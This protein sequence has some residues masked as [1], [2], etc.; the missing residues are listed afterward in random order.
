MDRLL[1]LTTLII[2]AALAACSTLTA[3]REYHGFSVIGG[4]S[5]LELTLTLL[6]PVADGSVTGFYYAG[7]ARGDL[8]GELDGTSFTALLQPGANCT[9]TFSGTLTESAVTGTLTPFDCAG[10]EAGKWD[11]QR[12]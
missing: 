8:H 5:I 9:F 3:T 6:E 12:Q 4:D 11:L 7:V 10:G 2:T 1:A